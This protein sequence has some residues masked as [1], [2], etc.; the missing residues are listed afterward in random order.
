[1]R[2]GMQKN[3]NPQLLLDTHIYIWLMNGD[4]SI[5]PRTLNQANELIK[6]GGGVAIS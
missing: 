5:S 3:P 2:R 1:M 6:N 4:K